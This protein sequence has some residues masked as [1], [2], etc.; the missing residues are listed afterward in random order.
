MNNLSNALLVGAFLSFGI[1]SLAPAQAQ[2][3]GNLSQNQQSQMLEAQSAQFQ[4][5]EVRANW[6]E[7]SGYG[8]PISAEQMLDENGDPIIKPFGHELFNGGFRG[9]RADG[10]NPEYRILPGDQ[11][12]LRI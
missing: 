12:T 7:S 1:L 4:E 8:E 3:F 2:S 10:L 5:P 11:I 9:L 6:R